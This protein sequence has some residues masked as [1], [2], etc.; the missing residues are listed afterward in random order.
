MFKYI[1]F[2]EILNIFVL[3]FVGFFITLIWYLRYKKEDESS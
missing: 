3:P 1:G 2:G